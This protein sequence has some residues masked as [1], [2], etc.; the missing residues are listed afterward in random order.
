MSQN[1]R[2]T[3]KHTIA[4]Q[5]RRLRYGQPREKVFCLGFQ[6][7]GTTSLQYAL[8]KLGYRVAGFFSAEDFETSEA[9]RTHTFSQVPVFDAFAD[10]PWCLYFRD[11]DTM[12]PGS[13][14]ILTTRDPKQWYV[15]VSKHFGGNETRMRRW[16]YGDADPL[17]HKQVYI[18]R[19][20]THEAAVR[21]HFAGREGD[22]MEFNVQQGDGWNEL[23]AFLGKPV[24]R[25]DF[26]RLNTAG[27]RTKA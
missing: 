18:D 20:L 19:L 14:F 6:K 9:L 25:E 10:N 3:L 23:C 27:M 13:K 22:F 17:D 7:T 1:S 16:I 11:F 2:L 26:P 12:F 4:L 15:S 8:S 21:D 5:L 24:P